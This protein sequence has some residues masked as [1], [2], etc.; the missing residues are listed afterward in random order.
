MYK[1]SIDE[2]INKIKESETFTAFSE[3]NSFSISIESY[4]PYVCTAIHNGGNIRSDLRKQYALNKSERWKEEDP[5]TGLFVSSLPIKLIV[6]DS[7]YEY[8]LN[9]TPENCIYKEAWGK[10]VWN[11]D[12]SKEQKEI[13]LNKHE[14]FYRVY[15]ALIEKLENDFGACVVYDIHSYNYQRKES[16]NNLPMF[17]V[18]TEQIKDERFK[19]Y[20]SRFIKE[21]SKVKITSVK[22]DAVE[23]IVFKG[24]GYLLE[25]TLENFKNVLPLAT[26]IKKIYADENT[27]DDFPEVIYEIQ[28]GL[29]EAI[30]NHANYFIK[31]MTTMRVKGKYELL[32]SSMEDNLKLVDAGLYTL[33]KDIEVIDFVNPINIESEKKKFFRSNCKVNP[34]FKYKPL[35]IDINDIKREMYKLPVEKIQDIDLQL[36]YKDIIESYSNKLELLS[37]RDKEDFLYSSLKY[38][39]K[40]NKNDLSNAN[41]LLHA[42]SQVSHGEV[43]TSEET[44]QILKKH[45]SNYG[46]KCNIELVKNLAA[47]AMVVNSTRTLKIRKG[48]T[49]DKSSVEGLAH[50]EV[51]VHMLTTINAIKQPLKLLRLGLHRNTTTQEGLAIMSEYITSNLKV[52]RLKELALRVIAINSMLTHNDF[53][54]TF[55]LLVDSYQLSQDTAFY[56]TTRAYRGGGLTKDYLYLRGFKEIYDYYKSGNSI[57]PLILGKCSLEYVDIL[58]ELLARNILKQ[59]AY[60]PE[61]FNQKI[62]PDP[63]LDY[64]VQSLK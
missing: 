31:N 25:Y 44:Y 54:E 32:P 39:G 4:V 43:V 47:T 23:N 27:G 29:K 3:D 14:N 46:F 64:I 63:I 6:H 49:F 61:I 8:D 19:K 12:P 38:F 2:I 41:F 50:H 16:G 42:T 5:Y 52:S 34:I 13:A 36:L 17:N 56:I 33:L 57:T 26:E 18:G 53:V 9:R 55:T 40:P 60:Y 21:L 30:V 62:K 48:T 35:N 11:N 59:P 7:R 28:V 22:V 51:G 10:K 45:T 24:Q 58:K 37:L 20:V 15:H 1:L